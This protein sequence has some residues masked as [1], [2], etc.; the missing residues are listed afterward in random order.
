MLKIRGDTICKPLFLN[1]LLP[2]ASLQSE[3]KKGNIVPCHK[4]GDKQNL[5]N[6]RPVSLLPICK[7]IFGRLVFNEMFGFFLANNL[8]APNQSGFKPG[9]SCIN[10]LLSITHEIYSSFDDGF[11]VRRVLL[12]ISKAFDKVCHEGI[13]FK[14]KQNGIWDDLLNILSDFLRNRKQRVTLNG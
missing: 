14:L 1:K 5:K 13:I 10:Q 6:Y 4:K 11:E 8:L 9:D 7:K 3:W 12:D 2:L